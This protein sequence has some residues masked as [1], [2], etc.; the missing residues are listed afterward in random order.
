M[1]LSTLILLGSLNIDISHLYAHGKDRVALSKDSLVLFSPELQRVECH[2]L[3][4]G[5]LS[6]YPELKELIPSGYSLIDLSKE[7]NL[8]ALCFFG[9][10]ALPTTKMIFYDLKNKKVISRFR[11]EDSLPLRILLYDGM[12]YLYYHDFQETQAFRFGL[13]TLDGTLA[14]DIMPPLRVKV[15]KHDFLYAQEFYKL[16]PWKDQILLVDAYNF[17]VGFCSPK[18]LTFKTL[19]VDKDSIPQLPQDHLKALSSYFE[20]DGKK[21]IGYVLT[22]LLTKK[23]RPYVAEIDSQGTLKKVVHHGQPEAY[24][25]WQVDGEIFFMTFN[26]KEH[27]YRFRPIKSILGGKR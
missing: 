14:E 27:T 11:I 2:D 13:Y 16:Y 25:L 8:M 15:K 23:I 5:K 6:F 24:H 18:T 22:T 12:L 17:M 21:Y 26:L 3:K 10:E 1:I 20:K 7:A 9:M 4:D 19:K